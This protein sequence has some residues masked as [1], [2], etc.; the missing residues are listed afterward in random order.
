MT[1]TCLTVIVTTFLL[2]M[3]DDSILP[4]TIRPS[5]SA[6]STM[7][8]SSQEAIK[9]QDVADMI[10]TK[11]YDP[12]ERYYSPSRQHQPYSDYGGIADDHGEYY[13]GRQGYESNG[14]FGRYRNYF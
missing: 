11:E 8:D 10:G 14:N 9:S 7:A 4:N 6:S 5:I 1:A 12:T 13:D 3:G 2:A